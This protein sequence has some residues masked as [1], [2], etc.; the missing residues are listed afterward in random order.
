MYLRDG[1]KRRK[2]RKENK[3]GAPQVTFKLGPSRV[4][5]T[6]DS[7]L[8]FFRMAAGED[9]TCKFA[10]IR[11]P[12]DVFSVDVT[13]SQK[14]IP[15]KK[16]L[17]EAPLKETPEPFDL[18]FLLSHRRV[19]TTGTDT[20]TGTDTDTD[21]QTLT[22]SNIKPYLLEDLAFIYQPPSDG[23]LLT[24]APK[25]RDL[26]FK[27]HCNVSQASISAAFLPPPP[28][29]VVRVSSE[30]LDSSGCP[31]SSQ[32]YTAV[33]VDGQAMVQ[34]ISHTAYDIIGLDCEMVETTKGTE[35][36]MI[37]VVD[38]YNKNI[39][40]KN[41]LP[42]STVLDYKEE[43]SG[44]SAS[45]FL[46]HCPCLLCSPDNSR[47]NPDLSPTEC[48]KSVVTYKELLDDLSAIIGRDTVIV[49]HSL[50]H[51]MVA[52]GIYHQRFVDT[53]FLFSTTTHYRLRLKTI[54]ERFLGVVIQ[55]G[56]HSP[57]EDAVAAIE[58]LRVKV[59]SG[60][61]VSSTE[62]Q[63]LTEKVPVRIRASTCSQE[64]GLRFVLGGAPAKSHP[65]SI[66]LNLFR[67]RDGFWIGRF[68]E[69]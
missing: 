32:K 2:K 35:L 11:N 30:P 29:N 53:S 51:D 14:S 6:L 60:A 61:L 66:N 31:I 8:S 17:F 52:L 9:E 63:I 41:V 34:F 42:T 16:I 58:A 48:S 23:R 56:S 43:Y 37:S 49:G 22:L 24:P 47:T 12:E 40:T 18:V 64:T 69:N 1:E 4:V 25:E 39:Y 46:N 27:S 59:A 45:S 44:L 7:L 20:G 68:F 55:E 36:G 26:F 3:E 19:Y 57:Y 10:T 5:L 65:G 67:A 62:Y 28:L 15:V 13:I 21:T 38:Q 54:A 33:R 50:S